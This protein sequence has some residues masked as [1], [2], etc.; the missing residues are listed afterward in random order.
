MELGERARD[1][2]EDS[3]L[4][5][6]A[7][8]HPAFIIPLLIS[9]IFFPEK[10]EAKVVDEHIC[11]V[12]AGETDINVVEKIEEDLPGVLPM[13]TNVEISPRQKI[14]GDAHDPSRKQYKAEIILGDISR[15]FV[16]D[17]RNES[18]LIIADEDLYT[19]DLNFVF[20][21][22]DANKKACIISLARLRNEFY[23]LKPDN[24]LFL[25]RALK[26]AVHELGHVLG[27]GH[28][29]SPKCVMYFSNSL[30][31]TDRKRETFCHKC[32]NALHRRYI[33]PWK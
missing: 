8:K 6:P 17:K 7:G 5:R 28:C 4:S 10:L 30:S 9:L 15:Q 25:E 21:L 13:T 18:V 29:Q 22:A 32:R 2:G 27:L 3:V 11:L 31:D 26:E 1:E 24:K 33:T 14:S 16:L 12:P 20:G 19:P 23:G